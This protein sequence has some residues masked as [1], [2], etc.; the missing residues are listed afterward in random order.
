M[1]YQDGFKNHFGGRLMYQYTYR[2]SNGEYWRLSMYYTYG[3]MVGVCNL[4]FTAALFILTY[5]KW[6]GAGWG[7]R[8]M[9]ILGCSLFTVLQPLRSG[10]VPKR[11]LQRLKRI[12]IS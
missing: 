6:G 3:S 5:V 8:A 4:I 7:Y 1:L 12:L 2:L 9:L 10:D 11:L